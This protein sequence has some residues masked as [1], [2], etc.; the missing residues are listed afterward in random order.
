MKTHFSSSNYEQGKKEFA[1]ILK[2][3]NV[4]LATMYP[5]NCIKIELYNNREYLLDYLDYKGEYQLIGRVSQGNYKT[6]RID[7]IES[8]DK[9]IK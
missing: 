3:L 8:I 7:K 2:V 9:I 4:E 1:D 5:Y 6:F